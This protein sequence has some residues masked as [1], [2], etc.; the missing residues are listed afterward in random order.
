MQ[1]SVSMPN[2]VLPIRVSDLRL[3]KGDR[4]VLAGVNLLI[5]EPGITMIMGPNGAGKSLLLRCLH[6]LITPDQGRITLGP[7]AV[8]DSR[9][10]QAMVFQHPVLLRRTVL[11]NLAF[12]APGI[13]RSE[14]HRLMEALRS[15]NLADRSGQPARML[16]GGEKQRLALARALLSEPALL[17]LDEA[18]ASLDPASVLLI[19][20]LVKA[21]SARGTKVIMI[22]H[23][24]GQARRLADEIVLISHGQVAEQSP[25]EQFLTA[26][27]T[28]VA[29]A[30]L[31]G[32]ILL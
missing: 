16:S 5:D 1:R 21:Q 3:V 13:A 25:A 12:A 23:D 10:Q 19:E 14:P 29:K 18:T 2:P 4:A 28:L 11:Q 27:R 17:L 31:A 6:G 22:S 9:P 8:A 7:L 24:Q 15:V 26:P 32:E 20:S 30:Y